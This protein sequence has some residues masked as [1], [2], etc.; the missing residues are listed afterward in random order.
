MPGQ[1]VTFVVGNKPVAEGYIV[2]RSGF[3]LTVMD[4]EKHTA[5]INVT[6]TRSMIKI[7]KALVPGQLHHLHQQTIQWLFEHNNSLAV[8]SHSQL[9]SRASYSLL[10]STSAPGFRVPAP[11]VIPETE[12]FTVLIQHNTSATTHTETDSDSSSDDD[13]MIDVKALIFF[14][15]SKGIV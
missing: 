7:T 14:I 6:P 9:H 1:L 15:S 2:P 13:N 3:L 11:P 10:P 8:V 4:N 12:E 5:R